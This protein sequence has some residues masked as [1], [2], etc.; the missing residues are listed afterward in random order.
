MLRR[1]ERLGFGTGPHGLVSHVRGPQPLGPHAQING[2]LNEF[3][4][5]LNLRPTNIANPK[6]PRRTVQTG[7]S[8][9][10]FVHDYAADDEGRHSPNGL[11]KSRRSSGRDDEPTESHTGNRP[12]TLSVHEIRSHGYMG[13]LEEGHISEERSEEQQWDTFEHMMSAFKAPQFSLDLEPTRL[14]VRF[15]SRPHRR[16][17][18]L[19]Y[20]CHGTKA[21]NNKHVLQEIIGRLYLPLS[22]KSAH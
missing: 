7:R 2:R 5:S 11:G 19:I 3:S 18:Y 1:R 4:A 9:G 8:D 12:A 15:G 14:R 6:T 13:P 22:R 20:D 16:P 21:S 17:N 10:D